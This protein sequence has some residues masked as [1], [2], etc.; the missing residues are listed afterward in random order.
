MSIPFM[1]FLCAPSTQNM[2]YCVFFYRN[3]ILKKN[4]LLVLKVVF[5]GAK[6]VFIQSEVM[7]FKNSN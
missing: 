6:P 2:F 7:E 4:Y 1:D 5:P 3:V